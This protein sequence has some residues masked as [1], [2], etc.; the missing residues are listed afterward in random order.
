MMGGKPSEKT[1]RAAFVS[2]SA[3]AVARSTFITSLL[4]LML[5]G[6]A[7]AEEA[8]CRGYPEAVRGA[9]KR[10]VEA[11][12]LVEHEAADRLKGLDTRP[13]AYLAGRARATAE[14]I[15]DAKALAV[16]E[17]LSRC[18]NRVTPV[19]TLC[20]AAALALVKAIEEEDAGAATKASKQ[21][22]SDAIAMCERGLGLPPFKTIY[23]TT[24]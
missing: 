22:Y 6:A 18:R 15:A 5:S 21:A 10:G 24:D 17:G 2:V 9:T 8:S 20:R 23:R 11:L 7:A 13:F 4:A 19:R 14:L 3:A 1:L 12:R 16:E